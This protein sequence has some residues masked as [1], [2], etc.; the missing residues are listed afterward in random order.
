M[1]VEI[2]LAAAGSG[3]T[4]SD[5]MTVTLIIVPASFAVASR[6]VDLLL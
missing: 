6:C 2:G 3:M 1:Y 4:Q 5:A